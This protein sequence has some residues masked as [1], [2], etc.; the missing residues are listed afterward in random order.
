MPHPTPPFLIP[1][2]ARA[3]VTPNLPLSPAQV[4]GEDTGYH[5]NA[6]HRWYYDTGSKMYYGGE[7]PEWTAAPS[8]LPHAARFEVMYPPLPVA[9]AP[10]PRTTTA[11][12]QR[13]L[14][15]H[16][17]ADVGGHAMPSIGRIGAAKGLGTAEEQA[18]SAKARLYLCVH[19]W[20]VCLSGEGRTG[21]WQS[22][23]VARV[24][25]SG[26]LAT[27]KGGAAESRPKHALSCPRL[28]GDGERTGPARR[29][30][31]VPASLGSVNPRSPPPSPLE[32]ASMPPRSQRK[33]ELE[34]AAA[35]GGP[36]KV[37]KSLPKEEQ[38]ALARREAARARVQ[39]RTMAG[40]G[41]L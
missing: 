30:Q 31:A 39:Q 7:P 33:R 9:A 14:S 1:A 29:I 35:G 3:V 10:P 25:W 5:Y 37:D 15:K 38:E 36:K 28:L 6:L 8:G 34:A 24:A 19:V 4:L 21:K 40:F 41:L 20:G 16:P 32:T 12:Q 13:Q 18:A 2:G 22:A 26:P 23:T 17:L 27:R 11:A